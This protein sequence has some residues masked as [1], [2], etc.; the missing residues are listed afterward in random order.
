MARV[1]AWSA[2]VLGLLLVICGFLSRRP[3]DLAPRGGD[4]GGRAKGDEMRC[5]SN[6]FTWVPIVVGF[7]MLLAGGGALLRAK[8]TGEGSALTA[9][10]SISAE[11]SLSDVPGASFGG[12]AAA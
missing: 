5:P 11:P 9:D 10:P 4:G 2:C 8:P 1:G 3:G 7:V 12:G 6:H